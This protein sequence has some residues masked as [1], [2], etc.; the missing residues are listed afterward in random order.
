[1]MSYAVGTMMLSMRSLGDVPM[2]SMVFKATRR[3]S[4]QCSTAAA[5]I[6]PGR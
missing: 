6:K 4:W 1:M 2:T 5:M 3:W